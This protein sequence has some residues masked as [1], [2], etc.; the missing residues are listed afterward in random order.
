MKYAGGKRWLADAVADVC[1]HLQCGHLIEPFCG[2]GSVFMAVQ[3][4]RATLND[5]NVHLI[6]LYRQIG[7]AD[8]NLGRINAENSAQVFLFNRAR[9]NELI[10][11]G[12]FESLESAQLLYYLNRHCFN[13]LM[14][15]NQKR[16]HFNVPYG[17]YKKPF[18]LSDFSAYQDLFRRCNFISG[19][20]HHAFE[21]VSSDS[22][23][24]VDPPYY[25][26]FTTYSGVPFTFEDQLRLLSIL[27]SVS[28]PVIATNSFEKDLVEAYQGAGFIVF[29][30]MV[31]RMISSDGNRDDAAEMIAI[32]GISPT[33]FRRILKA[34]GLSLRQARPVKEAKL[35]LEV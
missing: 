2:A 16:G 7:F 26:T 6:N 3:P 5:S 11:S 31:S 34:R 35:T 20:F 30:I 4:E 27:E 19:D 32:K 8:F 33:V 9:F 12:E 14:R 22:L 17:K 13:G 18:V 29:K 15:F 10:D 1:R 24:F 23:L 25:K 28:V 21:S